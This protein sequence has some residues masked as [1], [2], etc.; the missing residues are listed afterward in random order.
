MAIRKDVVFTVEGDGLSVLPAKPQ[1]G[2][3]QGEDN[4]VQVTF[5]LGATHPLVTGGYSL[6][7]ECTDATGGYDKTEV[8]T[9]D[10]NG[11]V[12]TPVPLAWTQYGGTISLN[13]CGEKEGERIFTD[14]GRL[15]FR[16][17]A[18]VLR[19]MQALIQTY[20]QK[21]LDRAADAVGKAEQSESAAA[22]SAENAAESARRANDA[23]SGAE[24]AKEAAQE[25]VEQAEQYA[26]SCFT[27]SYAAEQ[28]AKKAEDAAT[29]AAGEAS[30]AQGAT[31][32]AE[33]AADDAGQALVRCNNH[34]L[35]AESAATQC[36]QY[37]TAAE[38]A[39]KRAEAAG[40]GG[41]TGGGGGITVDDVKPF[42]FTVT[43]DGNRYT[44]S[45]TY[46]EIEEVLNAGNRLVICEFNGYELPFAGYVGATMLFYNGVYGRGVRIYISNLALVWAEYEEGHTEIVY[47][48][49][50]GAEGDGETDDTEAIQE[51]LDCGGTIIFDRK[52]YMVDAVT[53]LQVRSNSHIILPVGCTLQAMPTNSGNYTLLNMTESVENV[54]ISGGGKIAGDMSEDGK[55]PATQAG[56]GIRVR[57]SKNVTIDGIEV[58]DCWGDCIAIHGAYDNTGNY[59]NGNDD[60]AQNVVVRDCTLHDARRCGISI[61]GCAGFKSHNNEIYGVYGT[62]P[63]CGMDFEGKPEYP[64]T[65]CEVWNTRIHDVGVTGGITVDSGNASISF[66]GCELDS[67][68]LNADIGKLN[69]KGCTIGLLRLI[70]ITQ[71]DKVLVHNCTIGRAE[72]NIESPDVEFHKCDFVPMGDEDMYIRFLSTGK[73]TDEKRLNHAT[74]EGCYFRTRPNNASDKKNALLMFSKEPL[75]TIS[76][77]NCVFDV[78]NQI[79]IT[80]V[81]TNGITFTHNTVK[82]VHAKSG[83]E[84]QYIM[85]FQTTH[86]T[87]STIVFANNT[88]DLKG[89]KNYHYK[90]QEAM[91]LYAATVYMLN[92]LIESTYTV[93]STDTATGK[94]YGLSAV[95]CKMAGAY[96]TKKAVVANNTVDG[97][98]ATHFT[99]PTTEGF[100]VKESNNLLLCNE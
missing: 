44:A 94:T 63:E 38:A 51:A 66:Y 100:V 92:N 37:A 24:G 60:L 40:G 11:T 32:A 6:Y 39:A 7:I 83:G 53:R 68:R 90:S 57:G 76:F 26:R 14:C 77:T 96:N 69:L 88:V 67:L 71:L 99:Y 20:I 29:A 59:P 91:R 43:Q 97:L 3:V 45:K 95:L 86:G 70:A 82:Q 34:S 50:H 41:G 33:K 5:R 73:A 55:D 36:G 54:C 84:Y 89:V 9:P 78:Y 52:T 80:I 85:N 35:R 42:R 30:V 18:G 16:A 65:D 8:L 19:K 17:R 79:G 15:T 98:F 25:S 58:C 13:V 74:F 31:A 47:V 12:G 72:V 56:H 62:I 64:N 28:Y 27:N 10:D 75:D 1:D 48:S 21:L 87:D 23:L 46:E 22:D 2:G 93:T 81:A 49:D 61:Q 4:A